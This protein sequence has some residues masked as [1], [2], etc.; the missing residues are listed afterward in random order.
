MWVD[1]DGG[2]RFRISKDIPLTPRLILGG[3]VRYDTHE[4][5][6]ERV[7]LDYML[8]KNSPS[9][10][11]GTPLM[12]GAPVYASDSDEK[13]DRIIKKAVIGRKAPQ[14]TI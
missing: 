11:S 8:S 5:W 1:T 13:C 6:E 9:S 10:A 3:E 14:L 2:A 12:I 4:L 7:H